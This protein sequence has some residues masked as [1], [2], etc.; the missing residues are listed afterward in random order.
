MDFERSLAVVTAAEDA[1]LL[2]SGVSGLADEAAPLIVTVSALARAR[3]GMGPEADPHE[4]LGRIA[5]AQGAPSAGRLAE[6]VRARSFFRHVENYIASGASFA[7]EPNNAVFVN[8]LRV[9]P[10]T[11]LAPEEDIPSMV[12]HLMSGCA[13][14]EMGHVVERRTGSRIPDA[15]FEA[16][17][18]RADLPG[19]G[20]CWLRHAVSWHAGECFADA[21]AAAAALASG[22]TPRAVSA[23]SWFTVAKTMNPDFRRHMSQDPS[24]NGHPLWPG[25]Y[26]TAAAVSLVLRAPPPRGAS[27]SEIVSCARRAARRG[28]L[29]A[30]ELAAAAAGNHPGWLPEFDDFGSLPG[31]RASFAPRLR[32]P[33]VRP[34]P[35]CGARRRTPH[36]PPGRARLH[37]PE[38]PIQD[39]SGSLERGEVR[40]VRPVRPHGAAPGS[41][42]AQG[43]RG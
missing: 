4:I 30:C 12:A 7:C 15:A 42:S 23:E 1:R 35:G 22:V 29:S 20:N 14:H 43:V 34:G 33:P 38:S 2:R 13:L 25:I 39:G 9:P 31:I 37:G 8:I 32:R 19:L 27:T 18:H 41:R 10:G 36:P 3:N 21:F 28:A 5:A 17:P 24:W 11:D 16:V 6:P 26:V 40:R